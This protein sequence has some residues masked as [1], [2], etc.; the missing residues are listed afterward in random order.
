MRAL[1]WLA[2]AAC[3]PTILRN[4]AKPTTTNYSIASDGSR[5]ERFSRITMLAMPVELEVWRPFGPDTASWARA[6]E[7][8][9]HEPPPDAPFVIFNAKL[10]PGPRLEGDVLVLAEPAPYKVFARFHLV[11]Q[12]AGAPR[13]SELGD[14]LARLA[15]LTR[16]DAIAVETSS[17][18]DSDP[19]VQYVTGYI[20]QRRAEPHRPTGS[21]R[22]A[23]L[24]YRGDPCTSTVALEH[25]VGARLGY[26]PWSEGATQI[27]HAAIRHAPDGFHATLATEV[28]MTATGTRSLS[29]R[30]C[31]LV[32]DALV[33]VIVMQLDSAD[34]RYD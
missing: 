14:D 5:L 30:T 22:Q 32:T 7:T 3:T 26:A 10:P 27:I 25:E 6:Y 28:T 33:T 34:A 12:A 11:Y 31:K 2:I 13:E 29:G 24:E 19:R 4:D 1:I 8:A 18:A 17:F 16:A 20:L 9:Q 15:H 21:H 23:R